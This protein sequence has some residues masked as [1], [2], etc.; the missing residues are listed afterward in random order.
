MVTVFPAVIEEGEGE[1][2]NLIVVDSVKD[3]NDLYNILM[4]KC[5]QTYL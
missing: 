2:D 3:I 5:F 1:D 4:N